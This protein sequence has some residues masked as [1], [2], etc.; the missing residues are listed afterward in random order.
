MAHIY[1]TGAKA[2]EEEVKKALMAELPECTDGAFYVKK[3]S[4]D[5]STHMSVYVEKENPHEN[6][7]FPWKKHIPPKL[8]GGRINIIFCPIGSVKNKFEVPVREWE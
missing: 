4:D 8:M 5:T 1:W 2:P 7:D 3:D 6:M